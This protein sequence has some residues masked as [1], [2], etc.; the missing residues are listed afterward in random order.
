[1][2]QSEEEHWDLSGFAGGVAALG[3]FA[4]GWLV[5]TS[6][7]NLFFILI[8][9]LGTRISSY[10]S[11]LYRKREI[12][13]KNIDIFGAVF[14]FFPCWYCIRTDSVSDLGW[15]P[16]DHCKSFHWNFHLYFFIIAEME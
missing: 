11:V 14:I 5:Q 13:G 3:P 1:M 12:R 8:Y 2:N 16:I 4:R 6:D 9:H 10:Y 15:T 7:G